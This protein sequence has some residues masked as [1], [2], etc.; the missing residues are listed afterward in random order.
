MQAATVSEL[1]NA[2]VVVTASSL[3][4]CSR[5]DCQRYQAVEGAVHHVWSRV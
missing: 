2:Y 3:R 1:T 4:Q 5:Y